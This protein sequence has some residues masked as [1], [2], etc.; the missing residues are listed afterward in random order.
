MLGPVAS[1]GMW[2]FAHTI[3]WMPA[4]PT[5]I[6]FKPTDNP[7]TIKKLQNDPLMLHQPR[8]DMGYGLV[9]LMDAARDA[10]EHVTVPYMV[11]HGEGDRL[12]PRRPIKTA[13]EVLP[14]RG[15]SKLAVYKNGYHLLMRDKEGPMVSADIAAWISNHQAACPRAPTPTHRP[16]L[17]AAWGAKRPQTVNRRRMSDEARPALVAGVAVVGMLALQDLVVA[18]ARC[19]IC[20]GALHA[21]LASTGRPRRLS[22]PQRGR[23]RAAASA[24][25]VA[26]VVCSEA[27]RYEQ[28]IRGIEK[29]S[30]ATMAPLFPADSATVSFGMFMNSLKTAW[31]A[32]A[33][34]LLVEAART[35]P[36]LTAAMRTATTT[37]PAAVAGRPRLQPST[38]A[39]DSIS[40]SKPDTASALTATRVE[41]TTEPLSALASALETAPMSRM[42]VT[43]MVSRVRSR[44][45]A[46]ADFR[47]ASILRM[48]TSVCSAASLPCTRPLESSEVVPETKTNG[49]ALDRARVESDDLGAVAKHLLGHE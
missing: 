1:A 13:I 23:R 42:S 18:Q 45:V 33:I 46:P 17:V 35:L 38:T 36:G 14:P 20:S 24:V 29:R 16:K 48:V 37:P 6:D 4:G 43:K 26:G 44:S 21:A 10:A 41:L 3:P 27:G 9:D 25:Q 39:V 32:V 8:F 28:G 34:A 22:R 19:T 11:L 12:V 15:D 31:L 30:C 5:S 49:P 47:P 40:T 7:K 2:F